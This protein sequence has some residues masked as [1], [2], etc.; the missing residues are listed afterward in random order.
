MLSKVLVY[1][2]MKGTRILNRD[3][4]LG[5]KRVR[6]GTSLSTMSGYLLFCPHTQECISKNP[7]SLLALFKAVLNPCFVW[8]NV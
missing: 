3:S 1:E 5:G 8:E 6:K 4:V 2:R 7:M